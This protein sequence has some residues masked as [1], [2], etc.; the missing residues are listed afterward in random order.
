MR[1][2]S[3][4]T[5]RRP[6]SPS[7]APAPARLAAPRPAGQ[8]P[9]RERARA[10]GASPLLTT[11]G[12]PHFWSRPVNPLLRRAPLDRDHADQRL[13]GGEDAAVGGHL[14]PVNLVLAQ[15]LAGEVGGVGADRLRLVPA[16]AFP[17]P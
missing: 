15:R 9:R 1:R 8:A 11:A 6:A 17:T 5:G 14:H 4:R 3:T 2:R 10:A 12:R 7:D 16:V 13:L